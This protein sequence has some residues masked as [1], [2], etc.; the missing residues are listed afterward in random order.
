M[1]VLGLALLLGGSA[2]AD[3]LYSFGPDPS[4]VGRVFQGVPGGA[5]SVTLGD[6]SLAFNGG[7]VAVT[8]TLFFTI[9]NDSFANSFLYS[10]TLS[11][12]ATSVAQLGQGFYGGLAYDP[13]QQALYAIAS[14]PL[15]SSSLYQADLAGN[16]T[17]LGPLGS[18]FYGGLT[19]NTTTGLLY[20]F[21][22]DVTGA[23]RVFNSITPASSPTATALFTL[24]D[25]SLSF[26]GGVAFQPADGLFYVIS[27]DSLANSTLY[28]FTL[29]GEASLNPV[30]SNFG[31]GFVNV[32][33]TSSTATVTVPEPSSLATLLAGAGLALCRRIVR[34]RRSEQ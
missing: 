16:V 33:L 10:F 25:G 14:D 15:G 18:G 21:Q 30:A 4:G 26:N 34:R 32:G 6:G 7:V 19:F 1:G 31:V 12:S 13:A 2:S 28:S 22:G 8:D 9:A 23:Q 3:T 17:S 29:A 11:G 24:G 20:S 27:N 5:P